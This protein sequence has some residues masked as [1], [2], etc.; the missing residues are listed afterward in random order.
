M[1]DSDEVTTSCKNSAATLNFLSL[2]SIQKANTR[3]LIEIQPSILFQVLIA[4]QKL[5]PRV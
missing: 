2:N 5:R 1:G 3:K 4:S